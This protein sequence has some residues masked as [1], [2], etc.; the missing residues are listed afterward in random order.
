M[1]LMI[2]ALLICRMLSWWSDFNGFP[3]KAFGN[4]DIKYNKKP[5]YWG[6]LGEN[7]W[8]NKHIG[9]VFM[10]LTDKQQAYRK[11][12]LAKIH[13]APMYI[14]MEEEDYRD[15][16]ENNYGKRS[17][18]SLRISQLVLLLEYLNGKSSSMMEMITPAQMKHIERTWKLK[19][20]NPTLPGLRK[21]IEN[22]FGKTIIG[23]QALNKKEASGVI[24]M[25]NRLPLRAVDR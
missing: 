14:Q 4:D 9:G 1:R 25:L 5:L 20:N 8:L 18:G 6:F 22:N 23:I 17:A 16:L 15:M 21:F 2:N 13:Q 12:L 19:A 3:I 7:L 24:A 11:S 10:A